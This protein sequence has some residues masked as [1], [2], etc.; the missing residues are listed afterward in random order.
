MVCLDVGHNYVQHGCQS[1]IRDKI[2]AGGDVRSYLQSADRHRQLQAV[3]DSERRVQTER[4]TK[5]V[6][7]RDHRE[8]GVDGEGR[9]KQGVG[10]EGEIGGKL[11]AAEQRYGGGSAQL[12]HRPDLS[13]L[14][15]AAPHSTQVA[16]GGRR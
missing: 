6:V 15:T 14:P 5:H 16:A 8:D 2:Q 1:K 10:G 4:A 11:S 7:E 9:V 13:H 3:L 12:S